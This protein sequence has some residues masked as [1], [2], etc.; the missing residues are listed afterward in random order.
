MAFARLSPTDQKKL[1]DEIVARSHKRP[2]APPPVVV[3]DLDGTLFDNRPRSL[4]ILHE[5][6]LSWRPREPEAAEKLLAAR[7]H[8][9]AYLL[10]DTLSKVGV[11]RTDLVAAA[12]VYWRERFFVDAYLKF[13]EPLAGAVDFAKDC[14]AAG[15]L[16][17]YFTGRDLPL[18]GSGTFASLRDSG[19]P[20]GVV[21]TELVLKPDAAMPDE[22]FKRLVGPDIS[23][24]G[25]VIAVF[26]NEP[27]NCNVLGDQFPSASS[28]FV[29]TQHLPGA[30]PLAASVKVIA[31]FVR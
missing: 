29:D 5:L 13:D 25:D 17:V 7:S 31:D 23:R 26:D 6:A 12:E 3:F 18:M 30:P 28:C 14:Y 16:L 24:V 20:I 8:D 11:T 10:T 19:F 1:L 22:A 4:A 21:G 15:A 2:G 27:A 9:L